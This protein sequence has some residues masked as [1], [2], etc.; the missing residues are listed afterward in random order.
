M[1]REDPPRNGVTHFKAGVTPGWGEMEF[2]LNGVVVEGVREVDTRERYA[3]L[4]A[5][6]VNGNWPLFGFSGAPLVYSQFGNWT[7]HSVYLP[8][9]LF[10][11][12]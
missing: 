2:R 8:D 4:Y 3:L 5:R 10:N 11:K 9:E 6:D 7:A 1:N 12:E